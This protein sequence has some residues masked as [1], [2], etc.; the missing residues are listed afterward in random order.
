MQNAKI[1]L[2]DVIPKSEIIWLW[3]LLE[4]KNN[5]NNNN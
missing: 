2:V 5:N 3:L 1:M 4:E